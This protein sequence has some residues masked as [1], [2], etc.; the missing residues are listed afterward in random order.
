MILK[1]IFV[2]QHQGIDINI[3]LLYIIILKKNEELKCFNQ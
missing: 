1:L 2:Q 3:P